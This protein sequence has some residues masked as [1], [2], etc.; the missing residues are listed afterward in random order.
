[1]CHLDNCFSLLF[2]QLQQIPPSL[3]V[4]YIHS[5][6]RSRCTS[7]PLTFFWSWVILRIWWKLLTLCLEK[8]TWVWKNWWRTSQ[9]VFW[10]LWSSFMAESRYLI[11]WDQFRAVLQ[12]APCT[13]LALFQT[14][15][16]LHFPLPMVSLPISLQLCRNTSNPSVYPSTSLIILKDGTRLVFSTDFSHFYS[17]LGNLSLNFYV[18]HWMCQT[19]RNSLC[20]C[21]NLFVHS[22]LLL[23]FTEN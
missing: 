23:T 8:Y 22:N 9:E 4:P 16:L 17:N 20:F 7:G 14:S 21:L 5:S 12:F 2:N 13:S 19:P 18:I 11:L 15:Y 3:S 10:T 1:M 6:E